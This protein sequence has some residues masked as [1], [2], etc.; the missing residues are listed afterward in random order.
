MIVVASTECVSYLTKNAIVT[1]SMMVHVPRE[2]ANAIGIYPIHNDG[3]LL[4]PQS[5]IGT[6]C[7]IDHLTTK[8]NHNVQLHNLTAK[9]MP[10]RPQSLPIMPTI[11][12]ARPSG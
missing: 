9:G 1:G 3:R 4:P 8:T 6:T 2:E 5:T 12:T 11:S 7:N 10:L